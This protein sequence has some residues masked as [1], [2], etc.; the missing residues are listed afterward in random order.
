MDSSYNDINILLLRQLF[1]TCLTCSLQPLSNESFNS[2]F[3][4]VDKSILETIKSICD[5]CVGTIKEFSLNEF[6][7]LLKEYEGIWNTIR[8]EEAENA[9]SNSLKD[10]S[11]E[12]VID[13]AKSSCK[14]FALQTEISY[15]QDVA[16]QVEHQRQVLNETLAAREA[17]LFKLNETYAHALSRIKEVKDSI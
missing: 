16:K 13:N 11:I 9:Q 15:L 14:V 12:K 8:S 2:Q 10:E 5:D 4:G 17:Q 7:E 6:D 3:P 1:Q